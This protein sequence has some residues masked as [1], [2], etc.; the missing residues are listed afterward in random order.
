MKLTML[1]FA[2]RLSFDYLSFQAVLSWMIHLSTGKVKGS[3]KD[4]SQE[5]M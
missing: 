4:P 2:P 3:W 1:G 5:L